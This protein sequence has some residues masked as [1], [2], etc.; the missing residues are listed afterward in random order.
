MYR[1]TIR[2]TD[3]SVPPIILKLMEERLAVGVS[4]RQ[5]RYD[6]PSQREISDVFG[7]VL[8]SAGGE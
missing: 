2:A 1:V 3:E 7:N 6:G 5:E 8:V 4:T